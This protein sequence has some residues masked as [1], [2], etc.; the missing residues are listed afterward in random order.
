MFLHGI[1]FQ[2]GAHGIGDRNRFT[3][4][5]RKENIDAFAGRNTGVARKHT[6]SGSDRFSSQLQNPPAYING[7]GVVGFFDVIDDDAGQNEIYP[8]VFVWVQQSP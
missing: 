3:F 2:I 7:A 1:D 8:G 6:V 4:G 5:R